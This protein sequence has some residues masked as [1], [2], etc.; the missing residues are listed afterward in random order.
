LALH[1]DELLAWFDDADG[2]GVFT[3]TGARLGFARDPL[4]GLRPDG[5]LRIGDCTEVDRAALTVRGSADLDGHRAV[6]VRVVFAAADGVVTALALEA[7]GSVPFPATRVAGWAGAVGA[8]LPA[9]AAVA[10]FWMRAGAG[11]LAL[12]GRGYGVR[13]AVRADDA[14]VVC[15]AESADG[16]GWR[17]VSAD[18]DLTAAQL[19]VAAA[20]MDGLLPE[21]PAGIKAGSWLVLPGPLLVPVRPGRARPAPVTTGDG[22]GDA[23]V[24]GGVR[25]GGRRDG[26]GR[27]LPGKPVRPRPVPARRRTPLAVPGPDGFTVLPPPP[28]GPRARGWDSLVSGAGMT[29]S[30][31]TPP[32]S[33]T[34]TLAAIPT[35][36][37]YSKTLGGL[38]M[39]KTPAVTG[40]A[41]AAYVVPDDTSLS[42]SVF[43]FGALGSD[44]GIGPPPFQIRGI[45][46]G[47]GWNS[48]LRI[49]GVE[50]MV[51]FPFLTAL[52]DPGEIGGANG[53]PVE[54]LQSLTAGAAPWITPAEDE[55]WV[56]AGLAFS[57]FETIFGRAMAVV[58][59]GEDLSIAMLGA[60]GMDLPRKAEKKYAR[61]E[62]DLQVVL[63]PNAG[64][65]RLSAALTPRS[66]LIDQGCRLRGSVTLAI[67]YGPSPQAGDFMLSLGGYH[68]N[69]KK[70][71]HY[72]A[73]ARLGFDW[74][75]TGNVTIGGSAYL[76]V[77]P[78]AVMLGGALNVNFHS[79]MLRAWL[80][81]KADALIQWNP[82]AF[83]IGVSVRIGVQAR[84]KIVFV[85]IT[86]TVEIGASLSVFGPPTGGE[87]TVH[88]WFVEFT[89]DFGA[90]RTG[91]DNLVDW[92]GF[93][94]MLPPPGG[95]VRIT[96]GAGLISDT[97]GLPGTRAATG[98]PAWLVSSAGFVFTVDSAIPLT[99]IHLDTPATPPV[100]E[101]DRVGVRPMG[102]R[103]RTATQTITLT[104]EGTPVLIAGW[105]AE[106]ARTAV[107]QSLWGD[108][109][110]D[111]LPAPGEQLIGDQ[112]TGARLLSPP[113]ENGA[114]TG[115]ISA[116]N[117]AFDPMEPGTVPL[118]PDAAPTGP[119]PV[120]LPG[121]QAIDRISTTVDTG[122]ARD[123]RAALADALTVAGVDLGTVD[124][125][126]PGY[127]VAS[128][129]AFTAAPLLVPAG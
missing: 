23:G 45:A 106:F 70:P 27:P 24:G 57:C 107:P 102:E 31:K 103:D 85:T 50:G 104:L 114:T 49:P 13:L 92:N 123:A 36:P 62:I 115:Y 15:V 72:P 43:A 95:L 63:R 128:R 66:F 87:A 67:W 79:G 54:I 8:G 61:A 110:P 64:E 125:D 10:G 48:R 12:D 52:D 53:D 29:L 32:L 9:G 124:R 71:V 122:A 112:L 4:G 44:K 18:R 56:A 1:V 82:F 69:Y 105:E 101:G 93:K 100:Q 109:S 3:L 65:L 40:S 25:E 108:G 20:G 7:E 75:L 37:P 86:I 26:L 91:Q 38:L 111:T 28:T 76:A 17:V 89:I 120:R 94:D 88:L 11:H 97:T 59:T 96:P 22:I 16:R 55:V 42:P 41:A 2:A 35:A 83:D 99:R 77:T 5:V 30:Y 60:G 129:T 126:L 14:G 121:G 74:D 47:L 78:S 33:V 113:A 34:G 98:D 39:V 19:A 6:P 84:V 51:D 46:L 68:P 73:G 21:L 90:S 118:D 81:A 58:Q 117:L 127:A 80:V 119:T 116:D